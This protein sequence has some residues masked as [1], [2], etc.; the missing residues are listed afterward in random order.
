M[1]TA[2]RT[3]TATYADYLLEEI[4]DLAEQR[5]HATSAAEADDIYHKIELF[6]IE[7]RSIEREEA[8]S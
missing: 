1:T 2:T 8:Q 5:R 3:P 6:R 7:L 4:A